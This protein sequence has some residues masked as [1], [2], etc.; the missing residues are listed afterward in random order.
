MRPLPCQLETV[1]SWLQHR[2]NQSCVLTLSTSRN[3]DLSEIAQGVDFPDV[4][5]VC[6][7]GLPSTMVDVLQHAS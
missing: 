1:V 3:I 7:A 2:A 5:I 4:K 6:T